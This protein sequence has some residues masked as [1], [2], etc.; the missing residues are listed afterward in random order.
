MINEMVNSSEVMFGD[1]KVK[2]SVTYKLLEMF[3][4]RFCDYCNDNTDGKK[5]L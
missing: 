1:W 5:N 3:R 2:N 4:L